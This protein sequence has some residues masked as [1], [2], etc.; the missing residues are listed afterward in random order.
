MSTIDELIEN[1]NIVQNK[2]YS[3]LDTEINLQLNYELESLKNEL[4]VKLV[5][6]NLIYKRLFELKGI[7]LI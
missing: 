6:Q 7:G 3:E 4:K 2:I 1:I 5:E